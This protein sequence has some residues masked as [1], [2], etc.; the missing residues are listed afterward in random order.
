MRSKRR[1]GRSLR[2]KIF[3]YRRRLPI[4]SSNKSNSMGN[5]GLG[6]PHTEDPTPNPQ[7]SPIG[8]TRPSVP[9]LN[10]WR[11]TPPRDRPPNRSIPTAALGYSIGLVLVQPNPSSDAIYYYLP[12][13]TLL[14]VKLG[15]PINFHRIALKFT[16]THPE[17]GH[18]GSRFSVC[19]VPNPR[20][21][22]TGRPEARPGYL[23]EAS[24]FPRF[25]WGIPARARS[26]LGRDRDLLRADY[27]CM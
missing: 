24:P 1:S 21:K 18:R 6:F 3:D 12:L 16:T 14:F 15:F 20:N 5:S 2:I 4:Q 22:T 9:A 27:T 8:T 11:C 23:S 19:S 26:S 13:S 10:N 25:L 7:Q 17:Q